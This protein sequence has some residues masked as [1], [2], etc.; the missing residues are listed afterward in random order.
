[1]HHAKIFVKAG[2]SYKEKDSGRS[3][4]KPRQTSPSMCNVSYHKLIM[5]F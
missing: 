4:F 2:E 5:F 3:C 1:M